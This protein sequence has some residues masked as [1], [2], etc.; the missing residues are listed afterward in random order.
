MSP[1]TA[2]VTGAARRIGRAI[3]VDLARHGWAVAIHCSQSVDE[4]ADLERAI[5][6]NGGQAAVYPAD[7]ASTAACEQLIDRVADRQSP[8]TVLVNNASVFE[9]DELGGVTEASWDRHL[10]VN[11]RAPLFL[12]QRFAARLPAGQTGNV[13]NII[14]ERVW[15]LTA[16]FVSYS[17]SKAGLWAL[18]QTTALALAPRIR[19]NAIGPGPV[20]PSSR[21]SQAD[22]DRQTAATPLKRGAHPDEIAGA[23]R[24]LLS[25][26]AVTGQMIALDGGAHLQWRAQAVTE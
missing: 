14:D 22:F 5:R 15:N 12:T 6:A 21:Q 19:V 24:F 25:A 10:D 26:P 17:A 18:T 2:L 16:H 9:R 20:L 8:L 13:V 7:L 4:A 23:V 11:L 1:G 3:A